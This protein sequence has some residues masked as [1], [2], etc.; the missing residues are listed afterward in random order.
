[1]YTVLAKKEQTFKNII[2]YIVIISY[3]V[4]DLLNMRVGQHLI[5]G[6]RHSGGDTSGVTPR[7]VSRAQRR[8]SLKKTTKVKTTF[9]G[10]ADA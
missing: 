4:R 3:L 6:C 1:M 8:I 9:T 10:I 7:P 2:I 5:S